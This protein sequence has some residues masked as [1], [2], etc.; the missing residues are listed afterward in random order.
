VHER[1]EGQRQS[2]I[3]FHSFRRWFITAAEQ[4][5]QPPH[6]ISGVVGHEEGRKGMT[7]GTYSGGPSDVQLRACV[8]AVQ[9]P[10]GV[11]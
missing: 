11:L 9:L 1:A 2:R 7:L 6:I 4:A 10:S 5:S 8:E 3:D